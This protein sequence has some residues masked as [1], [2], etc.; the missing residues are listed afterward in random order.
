METAALSIVPMM[1]GPVQTNSYLVA[2]PEARVAAVI[3]PAWNGAS[4]VR[5]AEQ[6]GW[7]ITDI[8]L[9]HAHFD[10]F[11]G[12]GGVADGV[13]PPP[14]VAL[15]PLDQ[16]MWRLNG[17]AAWFG[18]PAF[19]PGPEPT[20][21]LADGMQLLL[22]AFSFEVRHAPG[23]APGHVMFYCARQSC[24][25]CGDVL[26]EGSVGRT[27]LPGGE[28]ETLLASIHSR[29]LSLPDEV[30]IYPGH[31]PSTTVGRERTTNPFLVG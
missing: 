14:R 7:Q 28:W 5:E 29:I 4:I 12:A 23:H 24:L 21:E 31:G 1:L 10:H 22:G 11:G 26:F 15:H 27:D 2:D 6:R 9:T 25:F 30:Q 17:G 20:V 18:I 19:D 16:P 8:W 13:D 3:D